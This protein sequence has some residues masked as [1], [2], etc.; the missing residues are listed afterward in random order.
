MTAEA[1]IE[2][3]W[4]I[5]VPNGRMRISWEAHAFLYRHYSLER[6]RKMAPKGSVQGTY[7]SEDPDTGAV[8]KVTAVLDDQGRYMVNRD[9]EVSAFYPETLIVS[10]VDSVGGPDGAPVSFEALDDFCRHLWNTPRYRAWLPCGWS[11]K[12]QS[13]T[14]YPAVLYY[15][16]LRPSWSARDLEVRLKEQ[17]PHLDVELDDSR[18]HAQILLSNKVDG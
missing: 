11:G 14:W 16:D 17:F 12:T 7:G 15:P 13:H 1:Q 9:F 3:G 5:P 6:R 18:R 10:S 2:S 8:Y 4:M